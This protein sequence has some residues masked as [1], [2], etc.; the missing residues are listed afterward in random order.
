MSAFRTT[1]EARIQQLGAISASENYLVRPSLT[2]S[3]KAANELVGRWM[4]SAGMVVREDNL[5]TLIGRYEGLQPGARTLMIGSHLD[6]VVDAGRYD[7]TLGVLLGL[8]AVEALAQ[9][10]QRMPYAIEVVAFADEEG[11]RFHVPYLGS[12]AMAGIL[13]PEEMQHA[14]ANGITITQAI[15]AYGGHPA[16]IGADA[17]RPDELLG[18]L[19]VHIEQGPLLESLGLQ[20]GI[21]TAIS[22]MFRAQL[23]FIGEAGHAGTVPMALRRD[24][25]A[26][27]AEFVTATRAVALDTPELVATVGQISVSPGA[28]NAIPGRAVL[29][30]DLRHHDGL[31]REQAYRALHQRALGIAA[32]HRVEVVWEQIAASASVPCAQ[33]LIAVLE[34]AVEAQGIQPYRLASGAGH[35]AVQMARLTD[36]AMMFVRC[37]AGISHNPAEYCDSA[38]AETALHVLLD[39]LERLSA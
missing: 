32:T 13:T 39:A 5:G 16:A 3:M 18:Y 12:K 22:G 37:R 24:A 30:L 31:V 9:R 25:L 15:T 14:D 36:V 7:G 27:A 8:A 26:A 33:R 19:E 17:R 29:S 35:D 34:A 6:T 21:V 11:L 38:D 1:F 10:G 4:Q 28:S 2:P 23:T 20:V